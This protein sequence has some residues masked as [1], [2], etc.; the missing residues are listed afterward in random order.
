MISNIDHRKPMFSFYR[1]VSI[2]VG[3][4]KS[5]DVHIIVF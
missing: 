3:F 2:K 4:A 5:K 1:I